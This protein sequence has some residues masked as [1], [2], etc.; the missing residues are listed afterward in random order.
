MEKVLVTG[1]AGFIGGYVVEELLAAD[2][3]VIGI[4]NFSKYGQVTQVL[5]RA[6][7]TTRL[8]EGDAQRRRAHDRAARRTATISSPARR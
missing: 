1:S 7:R 5:R 2:Y 8:V 3:H 6:S 4:D